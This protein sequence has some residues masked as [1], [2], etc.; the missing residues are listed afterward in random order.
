MSQYNKAISNMLYN[1]TII[2]DVS[3]CEIVAIFSSNNLKYYLYCK[4][5]QYF[6]PKSPSTY[7]KRHNF[8]FD[9]MAF[10]FKYIMK[11]LNKR[12]MLIHFKKNNDIITLYIGQDY[13]ITFKIINDKLYL[14]NKLNLYTNEWVYSDPYT[15]FD[16][17]LNKVFYENPNKLC[18][19]DILFEYC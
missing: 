14:H 6:I 13:H 16:L 5:K 4:Y 18:A 10:Y 3:I 8:T 12:H 15:M 19:N 2:S 11:K 9:D 17:Y 7:S 1:N